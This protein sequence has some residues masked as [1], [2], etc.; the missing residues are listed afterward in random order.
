MKKDFFSVQASSYARYRP[1][2]PNELRDFILD[3]CCNSDLA[4][5]VATGNGQSAAMLSPHFSEIYA[6]D[7]SR[8][9]LN[10]A[11][12]KPNI[13]YHLEEAEFCSLPNDS[14]DLVTVATALHWFNRPKF[15]EQAQRVMKANAFIIAWS[16]GGCRIDTAIDE[17][18]DEFN[19]RYLYAYWHEAAR[20][21]WD[22]RYASFDWPFREID[23]PSFTAT[24]EYHLDELMNY[25]FSWSGVQEYMKREGKNPLEVV[26][27]LLEKV[28]GAP[29][30]KRIIRWP[31]HGKCGYK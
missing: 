14:V 25:M 27:P 17:I 18:M 3:H 19:F 31:L 9:Q 30:Q 10:H 11:I 23:F 5:D 26:R 28:W 13:H 20:L 7:I 29:D 24:A 22:D 1:R 15:Y 16:Y 2:Y 8:E 12:T 4:W 21:N 6:S